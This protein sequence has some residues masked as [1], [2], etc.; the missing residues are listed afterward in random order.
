MLSRSEK[1][2]LFALRAPVS[3]L[4]LRSLLILAIELTFEELELTLTSLGFLLL[5]PWLLGLGAAPAGDSDEVW[6]RT[7]RPVVSS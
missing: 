5:L 6:W 4:C 3:S 7:T 1:V 2:M